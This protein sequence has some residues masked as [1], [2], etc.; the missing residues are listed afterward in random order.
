MNT[1]ISAEPTV[2]ELA[3]GMVP[4]SCELEVNEV[5]RSSPLKRTTD[6]VPKMSSVVYEPAARHGQS[7]AALP[8][9]APSG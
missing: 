5:V 8:T 3:A 4:V 2:V 6:S 9:V 1:V 7:E